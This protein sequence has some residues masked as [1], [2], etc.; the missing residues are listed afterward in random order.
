MDSKEFREAANATIDDS[1]CKHI[2]LF[3]ISHELA[4]ICVYS[5]TLLSVITYFE[6]LGDRN[7]VSTVEPGYLRKLL[8]N[9][10]PQTGEPWATIRQDMEGQIMPGITHW[11]FPLPLTLT[12][13]IPPTSSSNP[14]LGTTPVST[15]SSPA[16]PPTPLS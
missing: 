9:E 13:F 14:K 6:N 7:V 3:K 10:A 5:L 4:L 2:Y 11:Y 8:P 16:P 12:S 15:P 1:E